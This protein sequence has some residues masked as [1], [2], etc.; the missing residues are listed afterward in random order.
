MITAEQI[1]QL[2][3]AEKL[4]VMETLWQELTAEGADKLASRLA[5]TGVTADRV[6]RQRR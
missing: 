1:K 4:Q 2:S 5:S 3:T 6:C